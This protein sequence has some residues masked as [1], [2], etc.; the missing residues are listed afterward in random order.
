M[1]DL[2]AGLIIIGLLI[3]AVLV[4]GVLIW[5]RSLRKK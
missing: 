1:P 5:Y 3:E 2:P 4:G